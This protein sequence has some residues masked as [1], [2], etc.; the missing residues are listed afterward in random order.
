MGLV[1]FLLPFVWVLEVESCGQSVPKETQITGSMVVGKL[2]LEAWMYVLPVALVVLL[3]P[4]ITPRVPRLGVRVLINVLGLVAAGL[5]G[6][7]G[8]LIMFF[9][10]FSER[11]VQGVGWLVLGAFAG[12][13]LDA[14]LRLIWSIQEWLRARANLQPG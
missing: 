2:D 3:T 10:I 13:I 4:F 5:A 14:L 9:T 8:F 1:M 7:G 12:S 11:L 6:W